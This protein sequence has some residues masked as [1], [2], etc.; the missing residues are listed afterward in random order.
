MPAVVIARGR[1]VVRPSL[2][3]CPPPFAACFSTWRLSRRHPLPPWKPKQ[4]CRQ[5]SSRSWYQRF[6]PSL[7]A[8]AEESEDIQVVQEVLLPEAEK[9]LTLA[10]QD[11]DSFQGGLSSYYNDYDDDD[12]DCGEAWVT[13]LRVS[14]ECL[15]SATERVHRLRQ[16]QAEMVAVSPPIPKKTNIETALTQLSDELIRRPCLA[17]EIVGICRLLPSSVVFGLL[18]SEVRRI[19][20]RNRVVTSAA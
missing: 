14:R 6:H 11:F 20:C 5:H 12:D 2:L 4:I 18:I 13:A 15:Q 17:A 9:D 19:S 16:F 1:F 8:I 7:G 3:K 10:Q